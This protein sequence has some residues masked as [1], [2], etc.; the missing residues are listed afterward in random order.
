MKPFM[1]NFVKNSEKPPLFRNTRKQGGGGV[2]AWISIDS[3]LKDELLQISFLFWIT[4]LRQMITKI[5]F[6]F[7]FL[8]YQKLLG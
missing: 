5:F 1:I 8:F 4:I 3:E 7:C 2:L 6:G